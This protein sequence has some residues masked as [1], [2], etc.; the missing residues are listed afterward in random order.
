MIQ[1]VRSWLLLL[2]VAFVVTLYGFATPALAHGGHNASPAAQA[3][4]TTDAHD[5][6]K[7]QSNKA[8]VANH[9]HQDGTKSD[10]ATCCG[11]SCIFAAPQ[12]DPQLLIV[13][14][15]HSSLLVP[16]QSELRGRGPTRLDRPPTA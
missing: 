12:Y 8:E 1:D 7:V 15:P 14:L 11:L 16:P 2:A 6:V 3:T 10:A 9:T 13:E 5:V 4:Q